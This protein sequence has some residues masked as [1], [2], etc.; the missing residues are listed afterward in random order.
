MEDAPLP[1]S[2]RSLLA[3]GEDVLD[4]PKVLDL[5]EARVAAMMQDQLDLL[6][7]TLYRLDVEEHKIRF[8]LHHAQEP[9]ARAIA[10]L[11][12]ERQKERLHTRRTYGQARWEDAD[13]ADT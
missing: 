2:F 6:L 5:F 9:P 8:A 1:E 11:I 4:D 10:R 3:G 13:P 7:S 12:L